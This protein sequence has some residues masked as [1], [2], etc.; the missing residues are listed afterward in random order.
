M[1]V[2]IQGTLSGA[3][4]LFDRAAEIKAVVD[5]IKPGKQT[6]IYVGQTSLGMLDP[7][8]YRPELVKLIAADIK[9]VTAALGEKYGMSIRGLDGRVQLRQVDEQNVRL[10]IAYRYEQ[11]VIGSPEA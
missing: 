1:I 3:S 2:F 11:I 10:F 6:K 5:S 8:Q 4:S 9:M 7:E